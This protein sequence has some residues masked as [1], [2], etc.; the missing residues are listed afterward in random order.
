VTLALRDRMVLLVGQDQAVLLA[1]VVRLGSEE[2]QDSE[3]IQGHKVL[4]VSL[5]LQA[6]LVHEVITG[7]QDPLALPVAVVPLEGQGL[8]EKLDQLALQDLLDLLVN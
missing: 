6:H 8:V 1:Q 7:M 4:Q 2:I 3:E 5:D